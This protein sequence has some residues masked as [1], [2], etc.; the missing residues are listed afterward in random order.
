MHRTNEYVR[1]VL[2]SS[3]RERLVAG[4]G[5]RDERTSVCGECDKCVQV[6]DELLMFSLYSFLTQNDT[7][8]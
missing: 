8:L 2:G 3:T 1:T 7:L 4:C 6:D 5:A